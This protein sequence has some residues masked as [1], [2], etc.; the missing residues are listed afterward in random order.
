MYGSM[1]PGGVGARTG[2]FPWCFPLCR[3]FPTQGLNM[4]WGGSIGTL[5]TYTVLEVG[6]VCGA[7]MPVSG[8][9]LNVLIV[10]V[11]LLKTLGK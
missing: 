8:Y 10:S 9:E 11:N 2:P 7:V 4:E 5:V 6:V 1:V 3:W